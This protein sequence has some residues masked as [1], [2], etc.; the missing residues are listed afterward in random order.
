MPP[1]TDDSVVFARW[2]QRALYLHA[3]FNPLES[4]SQ[5]TSR[6][7]EQFLHS[8]RQCPYNLQ[9][10]ATPPSKLPVR[11]RGIWTPSNTWFLGSTRVHTPN[12]ISI[13]SAVFAG[14]TIVTDRPRYSVC[15]NRPHL[16]STAMR[17]KKGRENCTVA[18][19]T[20]F[21]HP[22]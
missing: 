16:R 6:S 9:W 17:P 22:N 1:H 3:S 14:L 18:C 8:S 4:T 2:R 13:D 20:I 12:S 11:M 19:P 5:T 21:L 10:A 15:N 7:V